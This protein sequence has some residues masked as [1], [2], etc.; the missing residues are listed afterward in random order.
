MPA[1]RL[2]LNETASRKVEQDTIVAQLTTT[3]RGE[4][5]AGVQ[6]AVNQAMAGALEAAR[7]V[8]GVRPATGGYRVYQRYD[9][10]GQPRAWE[11]EQDLVLEGGDPAEVLELVGRLQSAALSVRSLGFQLSRPVRLGV[12]DELT[13]EA[14]ERLQN[15]AA[16]IAEALDMTVETVA[17]L[18]IGGAPGVSLQPRFE[19]R[20]AAADAAAL[21]PSAVP[22]LETVSVEVRAEIRLR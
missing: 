17:V 14:I 10:E 3:A 6:A 11:A 2:I 4:T 22:D 21:P 9:R 8:E 7:G 1:T 13:L 20:M 15:R 18:E 16:A 12:E 19:A 5:A